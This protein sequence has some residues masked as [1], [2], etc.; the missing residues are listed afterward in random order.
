VIISPATCD[1]IPLEVTTGCCQILLQSVG[2]YQMFAAHIVDIMF[3]D[4][5]YMYSH[6]RYIQLLMLFYFVTSV[7]CSLVHLIL[8]S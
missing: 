8:A 2:I 7:S 3:M 6:E 1:S 4:A 5:I